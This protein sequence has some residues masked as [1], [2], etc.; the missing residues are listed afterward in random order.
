MVLHTEMLQD[1][2]RG[3]ALGVQPFYLLWRS[4]EVEARS[5]LGLLLPAPPTLIITGVLL[6]FPAVS[7]AS[8]H[9]DGHYT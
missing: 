6:H 4:Q 1:E 8:P 2:R 9:A 3:A 7:A 5:R